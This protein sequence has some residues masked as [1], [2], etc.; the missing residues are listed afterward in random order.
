MGRFERGVLGRGYGCTGGDDQVGGW[1]DPLAA[2]I[3]AGE[4]V[5]GADN[6]SRV[7]AGA[8]LGFLDD[9][10]QGEANIAS[11]HGEEI[12]GVGV[13]VDGALLE[14]VD[15]ADLEGTVPVE[16]FLFD[17]FAIGMAADDAAGFV[18]GAVELPGRRG[19]GRAVV[20]GAR[21]GLGSSARGVG[22][23]GWVG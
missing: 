15:P 13:A 3:D 7:D 23:V 18:P 19:G 22:G 1:I 4:G 14:V 8:A 11:A 9:V 5:D 6:V 12:Q 21:A 20:A 17:A 2:V 10:A 16:E